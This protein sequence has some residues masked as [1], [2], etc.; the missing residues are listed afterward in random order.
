MS[1]KSKWMAGVMVFSMLGLAVGSAVNVARAGDKDDDKEGMVRFTKDHPVGEVDPGKAL[2]YVVRP[3]SAA[4]GV[5]SW[6]LCDDEVLGVNR[7]SSYF[8]ASVDPGTH[9]FWSKS[10]NVDALELEV[11]AGMTYYIQ[12]RVRMGGF[13]ART[14]LDVLDTAEGEKALAKCAKHGTLTAKGREQGMKIAREY[15]DRTAE[16]LERR[17]KKEEKEK[18]KKE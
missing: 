11:E 17:A 7:G 2:V 1:D 9:V 5:K 3:T 4:F 16:D 18:K 6:F 12:Q 15:K 14:K 13:K 8:F 10:E